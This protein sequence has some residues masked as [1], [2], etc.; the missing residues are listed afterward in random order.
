MDSQV[1]E[2]LTYIVQGE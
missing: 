2:D 1:V